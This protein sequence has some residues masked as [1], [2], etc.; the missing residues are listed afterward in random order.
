[1][2]KTIKVQN[3]VIFQIEIVYAKIAIWHFPTKI[4]KQ[5]YQKA[6]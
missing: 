6:E 1:M 4:D 5:N 3:Y 2:L